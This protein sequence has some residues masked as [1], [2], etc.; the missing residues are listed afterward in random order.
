MVKGII[1]AHLRTKPISN[2]DEYV[3][4]ISSLIDTGLE[5]FILFRGQPCDKPL[6]PKLGR[7]DI[8]E[9]VSELKTFERKLFSDFKKR[10]V[11][12]NNKVYSNDW[13]LLALGQHHG[14]PT[15]LLDWSESALVA[16][17]FATEKDDTDV[18]VVWY[19]LPN[20][21]DII[22]P[23]EKQEDSAS[24][25]FLN[26]FDR[27]STK[28]FCP[29]YISERIT[30][31]RGWFTCHAIAKSG[32]FA[33]LESMRKYR[34]KLNKWVIPKSQ[35]SECRRKLN[36]MGINSS[37]VYPDMVGLSSYLQWRHLGLDNNQDPEE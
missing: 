2:F 1:K 3:E 20:D 19:F 34:N 35:F 33:K 6:I 17:F 18:G 15:R 14:L 11:A 27:R 26:P 9:H 7:P 13:D 5:G 22:E 10:Y 21:T 24:G 23:K 16:L 12:Y 31:Q 29:D 30:A 4:R 37:S 36:I 8:L 25:I 32:K 28:V